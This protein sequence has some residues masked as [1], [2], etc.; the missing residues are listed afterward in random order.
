M[1]TSSV[2]AG[3]FGEAY[4]ARNPSSCGEQDWLY[5]NRYGI[6]RYELNK[7]ALAGLPR[8][9]SVLEVGCNCGVQM[10]Q[11]ARLGFAN[12]TG[13]DVCGAA[14]AKARS[15]LPSARFEE[16]SALALPFKDKA[17]DLVFTSGVLI[18]MP[19]GNLNQAM[20]ELHRV[21]RRYIWGFE[22]YAENHTAIH[23]RGQDG[24]LWKGDFS[25]MLARRF[26]DLRMTHWL[27]LKYVDGGGNE[28]AMYLMEKR[29]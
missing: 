9:L 27:L 6:S 17:F 8:D 20:D 7:A 18:H 10:Q 25:R 12:L 14:L 22:Y 23:Y 4:T 29:Q 13:V 3:A 1:T 5:R 28:D 16:A 15:A 2:W 19:P 24:L 26:T 21:S 11:L